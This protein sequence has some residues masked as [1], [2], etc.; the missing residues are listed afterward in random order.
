MNLKVLKKWVKRYKQN[1]EAVTEQPDNPNFLEIYEE[2]AHTKIFY[3]VDY[4]QYLMCI[5]SNANSISK[6]LEERFEIA[7]QM[8]RDCLRTSNMCD[9]MQLLSTIASYED[10]EKLTFWL[11]EYELPEYMRTNLWDELLLSRYDKEKNIEKV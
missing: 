9:R 6:E 3:L 4:F 2:L 7:R 10:E 11:D 8:I 1:L 5:K